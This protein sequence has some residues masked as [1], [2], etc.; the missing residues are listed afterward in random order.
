MGL[1]LDSSILVA[2]E[3][4]GEPVSDLL[5]RIFAVTGHH[6]VLISA[7]TVIEIEHGLWR[8]NTPD[9]AR[10]RRRYLDEIYLAIPVRSIG[11]VIPFAD[12]QI[13]ITALYFGYAIITGNPRHFRMIPNLDVKQF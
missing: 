8:A 4:R 10:R 6:D 7:V 12:L 11:S 5:A 13:G 1:I 2:A 9:L 3:R